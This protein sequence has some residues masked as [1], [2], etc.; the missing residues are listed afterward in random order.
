MM[1]LLA[2]VGRAIITPRIG[3][4]LV[5]Y[6]EVSTSVHDDL[7]ARAL[8]IDD[9]R[10]ALA[11]C[12]VELLWLRL[13]DIARIQAAVAARCPL[14]PEQLLIFCTH[15]HSG[16]STRMLDSWDFSLHDRIAD[17]IVQAY[18]ARQ[19]A[20]LGAGFGQL[21]GYNINRRWLDRPADP[22]VGVLRVERADGTPL[23]ALTHYACHAVVMG[24]GNQA[25]SG[26]FPGYASR[27]LEEALGVTAL[28][29]QGG[30]GDVNPLTETVR[31]RLNA[32]HPVGTIGHLTSYYGADDPTLPDY[33]N[34]EDRFD[35]SFFEA[36]TIARALNDEV[37][38]VWR[39]IEPADEARVFSQ[40]VI[41]D[42]APADDEPSAEPPLPHYAAI[43]PEIAEGVRS[44]HITVAG[45]GP[46]VFQGQPGEAFSET[47]VA[48]RAAAQRLG[49]PCP[50]L[51]SYAN[52][53]Y[54]YL[55]PAGAFDEGGYE[56]SWPRQYGISRH[57]QDRIWRA[58]APVLEQ[59]RPDQR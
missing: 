31:Q 37:L 14:R 55:P 49:Y 30:A 34:I 45:V 58:T 12:S 10:T 1:T 36:E 59:H 22:A 32:G 16:P 48:F 11:L 27:Q 25:V 9:G 56:V 52:G 21:F 6:M 47:A 2:G 46:V 18:A 28:Y 5:D 3:A 24:G 7:V 44:I 43:L 54:G 19:P 26:D 42:G 38:R 41:V 33:W 53:T 4:V 35:G 50:M 13:P 40:Q 57:L 23:A 39:R 51:I 17:A 29:A 15:T 8:V 20:R